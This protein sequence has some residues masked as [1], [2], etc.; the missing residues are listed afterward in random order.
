MGEREAVS[1]K[2]VFEVPPKYS[3]FPKKCQIESLMKSFNKIQKY[4]FH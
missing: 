1:K 4:E 3:H 2:K